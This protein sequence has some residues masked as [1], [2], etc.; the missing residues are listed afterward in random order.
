M[1]PVPRFSSLAPGVAVNI[2]LKADQTTGKLTTGIIAEMLTRG[3]HPRGIKVRLQNGS[4]GRVQSL[5]PAGSQQPEAAAR[6]APARFN[7]TTE[8]NGAQAQTGRFGGDDDDTIRIP[9]AQTTMGVA[10]KNYRFQEDFRKTEAP[11]P[12]EVASLADYIKAPS[13]NK[14]KRKGGGGA[15]A[16]TTLSSSSSG[17]QLQQ[18]EGETDMLEAAE[19]QTEQALVESEFPALDPALVAAIFGDCD[20]I[21]DAR[22]VLTSL[23]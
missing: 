17:R 18:V 10:R 12:S 1:A 16:T 9:A 3:D 7:A 2:V 22:A 21:A 11:P 20:S 19:Q 4:V 8:D 13:R 6:A 14:K 15:K 23:S 5:A